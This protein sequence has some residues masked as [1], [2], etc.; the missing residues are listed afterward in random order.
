MFIPLV[1]LIFIV[2][3]WMGIAK[4]RGKSAWVG[5]LVLIPLVNLALPAYIAFSE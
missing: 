2:L 1:N 3:T 5:V 4:N